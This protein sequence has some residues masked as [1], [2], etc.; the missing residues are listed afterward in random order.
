MTLPR[1]PRQ[2]GCRRCF[3][4]SAV[5]YCTGMTAPMPESSCHAHWLPWMWSAE[6][7]VHQQGSSRRRFMAPATI[8]SRSSAASGIE[9][10]SGPGGRL[11]HQSITPLRHGTL[12]GGDLD[13]RS[14]RGRCATDRRLAATSP[15]YSSRT[16]HVG[17]SRR[18]LKPSRVGL[19]SPAHPRPT[20][21][22]SNPAGPRTRASRRGLSTGLGRR[23]LDVAITG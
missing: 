20:P 10:G 1:S 21:S 2:P 14:N 12:D 9:P 6:T 8:V 16:A 22:A 19:C 15:A 3:G 18:L 5:P 4:P 13:G 17:R 11:P 7:H 23:E